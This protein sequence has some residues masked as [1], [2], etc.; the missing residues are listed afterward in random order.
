MIKKDPDGW[1]DEIEAEIADLISIQEGYDFQVW[2]REHVDEITKYLLELT[3]ELRARRNDR[4]WVNVAKIYD[5]YGVDPR[6]NDPVTT[7][8]QNVV[9]IYNRGL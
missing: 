1:E 5:S 3:E 8:V 2:P 9:S 7:A 6:I 4:S